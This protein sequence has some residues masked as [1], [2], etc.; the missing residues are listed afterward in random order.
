MSASITAHTLPLPGGLRLGHLRL[1]AERSLNALDLGMVEELAST[2]HAWQ[3]DPGI[4]MVLLDGAGERAF[5]AGGDVRRLRTSI[6][7][8]PAGAR[9][10]DAEDFF[11]HEY[12]LDH[13]IHIYRKPILVWGHGVVMGGGLGLMA[14]ASHRVVTASSRLAMPE[15]SIGLFPDVAASWFLNRLPPPLGRFLGMTGAGMN[16]ADALFV[17]LAD[18]YLE[19]AQHADL[20]ATLQEAEFDVDPAYN[21]RLLSHILRSLQTQASP[22]PASRL[23]EHHALITQLMRGDSVLEVV[24]QLLACTTDDA[25]LQQA[26]QNL[27]QGSPLTAAIVFEQLRRAR[28]L[29]LRECFEME[30]IV[31]LNC[32]QFGD[33]AEGVR[34]RL[35]DKDPAPH[36]RYVHVAAVDVAPFFRWPAA[37]GE[38]RH[39]FTPT[40]AASA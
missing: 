14:G 23:Y 30:F 26:R 9:N 39:V 21:H 34:A 13:L 7:E 28:H 24:S 29:S 18:F 33:F 8:R 2:L 4:A 1:Q 15:I 37:W 31:A 17:G 25:W 11:A 35:I 16:A 32:C 3:E 10:S 12:R 38:Q 6:L 20:I 40:P 27:Q 36:W 19:D 5:C 22:L